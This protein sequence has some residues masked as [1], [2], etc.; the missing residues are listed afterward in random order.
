[1]FLYI[2]TTK[3]SLFFR[4][5]NVSTVVIAVNVNS[6]QLYWSVIIVKIILTFS[7]VPFSD[8]Q[9]PIAAVAAAMARVPNQEVPPVIDLD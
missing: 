1:M 5:D 7:V 2:F 6:Y 3:L 4:L 8:I 9:L